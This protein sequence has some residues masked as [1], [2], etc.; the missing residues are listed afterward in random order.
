VPARIAF[1]DQLKVSA[2]FP[3]VPF[4]AATPAFALFRLLILHWSSRKHEAADAGVPDRRFN[5]LFCMGLPDCVYERVDLPGQ[6]GSVG[7]TLTFQP[8]A[9]PV[10]W[11]VH[12]R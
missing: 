9:F 5:R 1:P 11:T 10:N 7:W 12:E 2:R 4:T 3:K 8:W 6:R